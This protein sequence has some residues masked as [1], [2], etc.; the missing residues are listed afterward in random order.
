MDQDDN[1]IYYDGGFYVAE[2]LEQDTDDLNQA[3]N[4]DAEKGREM[5]DLLKDALNVLFNSKIKING[6]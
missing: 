1:M 3:M 4:L 5:E 6:L 2:K